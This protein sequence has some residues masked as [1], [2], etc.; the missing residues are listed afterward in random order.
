MKFRVTTDR[1]GAASFEV[2]ANDYVISDHNNLTLYDE[3]EVS[4]ASFNSSAWIA[5][6]MLPE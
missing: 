6:V 5:I 4:V 2:E 1:L 3:A